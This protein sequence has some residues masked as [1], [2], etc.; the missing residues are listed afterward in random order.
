MRAGVA[1]LRI[2]HAVGSW[3]FIT[4]GLMLA[5]FLRRRREKSRVCLAHICL[6]FSAIDAVSA[7]ITG[8]SSSINIELMA[9]MMSTSFTSLVSPCSNVESDPHPPPICFKSEASNA[10]IKGISAMSCSLRLNSDVRSSVGSHAGVS[11]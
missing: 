10:T 11:G 7:R 9:A 6:I 3:R 1:L 5:G 8:I 2:S 4:I